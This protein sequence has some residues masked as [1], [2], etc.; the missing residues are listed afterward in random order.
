MAY[1]CVNGQKRKCR[2]I[3]DDC[4][5]ISLI[6][7]K[8]SDILGLHGENVSLSM[9][10]TA[11]RIEQVKN[12]KKV[13]FKLESILDGNVTDYIT[14]CTVPQI[15]Q[16]M[17]RIKVN[18]LEYEH[19]KNIYLDGQ[20]TETLPMPEKIENYG[21]EYGLEVDILIGQPQAV[22]W[23]IG[24]PV[25]TEDQNL[26]AAQKYNLG[27]ALSGSGGENG[28]TV[29]KI[30][31]TILQTNNCT[32]KLEEQL[33]KFHDIELIGID[34]PPSEDLFTHNEQKAIDMMNKVTTYNADTKTYSTDFLWKTGPPM[35][36]DGRRKA[37]ACCYRVTRQFKNDLELMPMI[38]AAYQ[39][40]LD[41][42]FAREVKVY[43]VTRKDCHY[44]ATFPIID[45]GR[46]T[47]VRVVFDAKQKL[48]NY[49]AS[50]NE[51]L[52]PGPTCY[53]PTL[54]T[55][56]LNFRL[57]ELAIICDLKSMFLTFHMKNPHWQRYYWSWGTDRL[58]S[59]ELTRLGFGFCSSPFQSGHIIFNHSLKYQS[60]PEHSEASKI[61][62][63]RIY[64]DDLAFSINGN[65]KKGKKLVK[66]IEHIFSEANLKSHK[67]QTNIPEL[68]SDINEKDKSQNNVTKILGM[69]WD[70][71]K[72]VLNFDFYGG[73]EK[74]NKEHIITTE[75]S[76]QTHS[77]NKQQNTEESEKITKRNILSTISKLYD[78]TGMIQF[79]IFYAK[80]IMA[81]I[82]KLDHGWDNVIEDEDIVERF[83]KF[84]AEIPLLKNIVINRCFI[85]WEY[86]PE[87]IASFGDASLVGIC[88][89]TY[90]VSSKWQNGTK[91]MY[92]ALVFSKSR[93]IS[94][95]KQMTVPQLELCASILNYRSGVYVKK[96]LELEIPIYFFSD[97][98]IT[99]FRIR[100]ANYED[101]KCWVSTRMI[102][103]LNHT[104]PNNWFH[105]DGQDMP[106]D[107]GSRGRLISDLSFD[108]WFSGP[109]WLRTPDYKFKLPD[110]MTTQKL[111]TA[112]KD[113]LKQKI[114]TIRLTKNANES[115]EYVLLHEILQWKETL[116]SSIRLLA[117]ILRFKRN[118]LAKC[119]QN[120][121]SQSKKRTRK[122]VKPRKPSEEY[123]SKI[124]K[125]YENK[126]ERLDIT[127]EY[128]TALLYFIRM[129][130][131]ECFDDLET[132]KKD[133]SL[134]KNGQN[135]PENSSLSHLL[136]FYDKEL[137][138]IRMDSRL[139][140]SD[141]F[142][143]VQF[144]IIIPK[145]HVLTE[146]MVKDCHLQHGHS[147][148]KTTL[149]ILRRKYWIQGS[150]LTIKKHLFGNCLC[151]PLVKVNPP[152]LSRLNELRINVKRSFQNIQ[153]DFFGPLNI[154]EKITINGETTEITTKSYGCI[155]SDY[156]SR[157]CHIELLPDGSTD[158]FFHG[159]KRFCCRRGEPNEIFSDC[160]QVFVKS[161]K[162]LKR[163]WS[164]PKNLRMSADLKKV[165]SNYDWNRI[166]TEVEKRGTRWR[167]NIPKMSWA[168]G[169]VE[170]NI[171]LVKSALMNTVRKSKLSYQSMF[172]LVCEA[173]CLVNLRPLGVLG[174]EGITV[175]PSELAIGRNTNLVP[176]DGKIDFSKPL[177]R[178]MYEQKKLT[179][180]FFRRWQQDYLQNLAVSRIWKKDYPNILKKG[181]HVL[182]RDNDLSKNQWM[183]GIITDLIRSNDGRIRSCVLKN[184]KGN[185]IYRPTSK[186]SI[187]E[188]SLLEDYNDADSPN[189]E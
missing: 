66:S 189:L 149:S 34:K 125:K 128:E 38:N 28:G 184:T 60:D 78:P 45:F 14:A 151:R 123:Y 114:P 11:G 4:S 132:G 32:S 75:K 67:W 103:I 33:A 164:L 183:T 154:Y 43:D 3:I 143:Q 1:L 173:E 56:I 13:V 120:K 81:D 46:N 131:H 174:S 133:Y 171:G 175:T 17:E 102:E 124:F 74:N 47:K 182:V 6:S 144:P 24:G 142:S 112:D 26:P 82:W 77:H 138:V 48:K 10:V 155:F 83:R 99:V 145:D 177:S 62:C 55:I 73:S 136:P 36:D 2:I 172:T 110:S 153:I 69:G 116:R 147:N 127:T 179:N 157:C 65:L 160:A 12:Q 176:D 140:L 95:K 58:H 64:V 119:K 70:S 71:N 15:C 90:L 141:L 88:S 167:H 76:Q 134:I 7:K 42:G 94:E 188:H 23:R 5:Q 129:A 98:E 105:C 37:Q 9:S 49:D 91:L 146:K 25:K 18:P 19:L 107:Q 156:Y 39:K 118:Y 126:I 148:L 181:M 40:F 16:P 21:P 163:I 122:S 101:Y 44:L 61:I 87:F 93:I 178:K 35:N 113:F 130:Q 50:F 68:L 53:L 159:Y 180:S 54:T 89:N 59:Y 41:E 162:E 20:F 109:S 63:K 57:R 80:R 31:Y 27:Y 168:A 158:S 152:R 187:F 139:Q 111:K 30:Q 108:L 92:S 85:P 186:I 104:S 29:S 137:K 165:I 22:H 84:Q 117:W 170:R 97:S 121:E 100:N 166:E 115:K 96:A 150:T 8:V 79:L 86:E 185:T 161:A 135:V 106:S 72:D 169:L 52:L 51:L